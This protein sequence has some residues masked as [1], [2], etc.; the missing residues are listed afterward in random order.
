MK[1]NGNKQ[2][3]SGGILIAMFAILTIL[4][5]IVDVRPWGQKGTNIG[6]A[7]FRWFHKLTGANI[8][9]YI[10]RLLVKDKRNFF[11][12]NLFV[13]IRHY[14]YIAVLNFTV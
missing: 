13:R 1:E 4:I 3:L 6:F 10:S 8:A 2:L 7:V 9:L 12:Q 5:Q 14:S 11:R